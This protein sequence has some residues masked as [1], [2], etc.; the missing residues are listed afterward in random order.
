MFRYG[1][2]LYGFA[3]RTL[4]ELRRYPL[5]FLGAL[6]T[7]LLVFALIFIG[8]RALA[9]DGFESNVEAIIVGY[10]LLTTVLSTFFTLS[11]LINTEA[12][13]GTLQQLYVSPFRFPVV[14]LAAVL[15][16][17]IVA[18]SIGMVTLGFILVLTGE[19]L[20]IDLFTVVPILGLT[21]LQ[22]IGMGF[23]L[24]GI[25]LVYKRIRTLFSTLQFAII[26]VLS[27]ALTDAF[28]PRLLPVGQGAAMLHES[29]A[30][31][32][33]LLD[34]PLFDHAILV[35]TSVVYLLIGYLA[36]HI[37]QHH[38]RTKGLLDDY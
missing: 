38:A 20:T 16:N 30:N 10:F 31:G 5:N 18:L 26:G 32:L 36:F 33:L 29:M 6:L 34:F 7:Y 3:N 19:T 15:G 37:A 9:P 4:I 27:L 23:F 24:G 22:A 1:V 28:W 17:M 25:A 21:I 12:K 35:S 11:G 14:M 13:Y 2:L 8:G